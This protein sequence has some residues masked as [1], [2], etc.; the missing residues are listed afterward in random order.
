MIDPLG[1]P[2]YLLPFLLAF[3]IG[4]L[5]GSIPFGL[6]LTHIFGAGDVRK[7][8]SGSI[9]ATNVLRT[10]R[11]GLAIATLVADLLKG[12][13][14]TILASYLFGP[15]IA[16]VT[17]LGTVLGHCFTIWLRFKGG[18]GVATATGVIL[19]L[20]PLVILLLLLV[21]ALVL[22]RTRFVSLASIAGAILAPIAAWMLGEIQ[23]A[24]LY[25]LLALIILA[26]HHENIGRLIK[27]RE[28]K[29][30]LSRK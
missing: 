1:G 29:L 2:A 17:A 19:A 23:I 6:V 14:P 9:G 25:V 27:G 20:T 26:K 30:D 11:K 10:G 22:W 16:V 15:D 7:I 13:L 5:A 28:N 24:E 12:Y 4:Y 3:A 21:F 8:G 18:K